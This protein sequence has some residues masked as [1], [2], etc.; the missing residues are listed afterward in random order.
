MDGKNAVMHQALNGM[1]DSECEKGTFELK[2]VSEESKKEAES[3]RG[4]QTICENGQKIALIPKPFQQF[5]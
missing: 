2:K 4:T 1:S 5:C 3:E